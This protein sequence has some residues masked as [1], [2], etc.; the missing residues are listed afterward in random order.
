MCP[1]DTAPHASLVYLSQRDGPAVFFFQVSVYVW[2]C[3]CAKIVSS[4]SGHGTDY[5]CACQQGKCQFSKNSPMYFRL[6]CVSVKL[7]VRLP[8]FLGPAG[9]CSC[10]MIP[11]CW[12]SLR[13]CPFPSDCY[14]SQGTLSVP[15]HMPGISECAILWMSDSNSPKCLRATSALQ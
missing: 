15:V 12:S 11:V 6:T 5:V 1:C 14:V 8:V 3:M 4:V 9:G 10:L 2:V 7:R 13:A